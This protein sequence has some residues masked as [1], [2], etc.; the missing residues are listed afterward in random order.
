MLDNYKDSQ[1]VAY[2]ILTNALDSKKISHAYLFETNGYNNGF[3]MAMSFAKALLCKNNCT[4]NLECNNCK[5]CQNID[6]NNFTE[7]KIIN[8]DGMWIKKEQLVELQEE[9][10]KKSIIG[11][12][13]IYII[14]QADRLNINA[15]NMIL[16]FVEEPPTGIIAIFVVDNIY[17]LLDTIVSRCQIISLNGQ[18]INNLNMTTE[19]KLIEYLYTDKENLDLDV[20]KSKLENI[21][22]FIIYYEE[23]GKKIL[24]HMNE[25]FFEY[26]S[27]KDDI[28]NVMNIIISFYRDCLYLKMNKNIEFFQDYEEKIKYVMNKNELKMLLKKIEIWNNNKFYINYNAN[29]N[30]LMDRIIIEIEEGA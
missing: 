17:N 4:N 15:S 7:L 9:F 13:K 3:D 26:F 6:E 22:K 2:K 16:K 23:N 30:L 25:Y 12:Y 14:N 18:V 21:I 1:K 8:P 27:D 19:Q 20:F 24:L 5:Q 29:L 28:T 10:N 11:N